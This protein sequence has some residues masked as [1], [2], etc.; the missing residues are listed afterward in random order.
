MPSST[1]E[2]IKSKLDIVDFLRGYLTLQPA[3]KNF[4]ALCPFHHEKSPSFS[5]SPERQRFHCFG[6]GADGDIFGFVMKYENMEFGEALRML[7][8]KAGVELRHENPAEYRFTGLLYDLNDQAKNF[9]KKA[10][11]AALIVKQ[12][13]AER[14]LTA[15]TIEEFELGWAANEPE[16]LSM[17]LLN[18]GAAPQDLLQAG[19]SIKTER[20]LMLDR[21]RGRVMFPIHNHLGKVVGFTGRILPQFDTSNDPKAT[22]VTAKYVNSPETPIFQKSKLL[23]GFWKSKDAIREAKV[24]VLVEGQMDFLMSYQSGVKNVIASSGTALTVDHLRSVHRL[25]DEV[26]LCFDSDVAGSDAAER[27][28]DLAE[29]N[30]FSV[31]VATYRGFKDA[32][33]AAKA[34]PENIQRTVAAAVS[35]PLFYFEKYLPPMRPGAE[36]SDPAS[37]QSRDGLNKLRTVLLKLRNIASPVEREFWLKELAKRTG[38][39]EQTLKD[40]AERSATA[41][42]SPAGSAGANAG[43]RGTIGQDESAP[44]RQVPRQELIVEDLFALALARNDFAL[45][46]DCATFFTPAQ[47]E[48]FTLLKSGKRRSDDGALD[49]V[50]NLIVLRDPTAASDIADADIATLKEGLAKEYYKE[51][52]HILSLAIKN[53]EVRGNDA[54]LAAALAELSTL[55]GGGE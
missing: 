53:A 41:Q 44:Q 14:G 22:Y 11:G 16:G 49:A 28:I 38:M 51:R 29:A 6:C 46:E 3:G 55:P 54:E 48:I 32:A 20:G 37:L 27:A 5:I 35:A 9:Y 43:T 2:L 39:N 23:Y 18:G 31:K 40:E 19:L 13:L 10:L 15:E 1:T 7:A 34:D 25:A 30:D 45:I 24:A 52:R 8:E 12:Y 17:H 50:I 47:K 26:V 21:F 36:S 4:K 42:Y 33:E